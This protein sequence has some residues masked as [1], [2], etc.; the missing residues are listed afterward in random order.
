[1]TVDRYTSMRVLRNSGLVTITECGL[2]TVRRNPPLSYRRRTSRS[3]QSVR[4]VCSGSFAARQG[5]SGARSRPE[6]AEADRYREIP[7]KLERIGRYI[8][9]RGRSG[10]VDPDHAERKIAVWRDGFKE[11]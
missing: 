8:P 5:E 3:A 10:Q 9:D 1:M 11:I 2:I 7:R 4:G 6:L